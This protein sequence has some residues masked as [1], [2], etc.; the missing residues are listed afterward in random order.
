M[1]KLLIGFAII[2]AGTF[3]FM[4]S[5]SQVFGQ[6]SVEPVPGG[7]EGEEKPCWNSITTKNGSMVRYCGTCDWVNNATDSW[8]TW[9]SSC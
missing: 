3:S 9:E 4:N 8:Y 2:L 7:G 1:R 6:A 5:G